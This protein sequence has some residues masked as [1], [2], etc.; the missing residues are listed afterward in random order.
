LVNEAIS[1]GASYRLGFSDITYTAEFI[2]EIFQENKNLAENFLNF[3]SK[4]V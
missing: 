1:Y 2:Q 4:K 3:I